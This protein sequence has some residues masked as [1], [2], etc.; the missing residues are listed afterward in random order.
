M[1]DTGSHEHDRLKTVDTTKL[2]EEKALARRK[3]EAILS[4]CKWKD[5]ESLK[6]LAESGG[7]FLSDE[8]RREACMCLRG[9]IH[10]E[11]SL[12]SPWEYS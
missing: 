12:H 3:T 6:S 7:G 4:A 2:D 11:I 5:L 8:N 9:V 10:A 1:S